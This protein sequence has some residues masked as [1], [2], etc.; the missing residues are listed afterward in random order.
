MNYVNVSS[1]VRRIFFQAIKIIYIRVA[2]SQI[3]KNVLKT[4]TQIKSKKI[5]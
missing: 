1:H 3:C 5:L 4:D 2:I